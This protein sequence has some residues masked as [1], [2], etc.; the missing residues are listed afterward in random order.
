MVVGQTAADAGVPLTVAPRYGHRVWRTALVFG[1]CVLVAA[2][3]GA[4][5]EG[6][7]RADDRYAA[8]HRSLGLTE[9]DIASGR[10]ELAAGLKRLDTLKVEVYLSTTQLASDASALQNA[11]TALVDAQGRVSKQ[12]T[13]ITVLRSC[14]A[15]VEQALNALSVGD[16]RSAIAAL[17]GSRASCAAAVTSFG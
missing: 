11:R 17:D 6:V 1:A 5:V 4:L 10:A 15:G 14:L 9:R 8:A 12:G 16:E 13:S 3:I 2:L 7:V